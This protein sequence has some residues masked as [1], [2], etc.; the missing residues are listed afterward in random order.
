MDRLMIE[1]LVKKNGMRFQSMIAQEEC[2]EL[3]Q[4]ISKCLRSKDFPVEHERENLIEEM[5]DVMICLQQLQY[6]YYIDDEELYA[7]KQ[8]KENRLIERE[9]LRE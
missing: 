5:A 9:G 6:M 8:K 1:K 3:I 7:M 2:A 4:A